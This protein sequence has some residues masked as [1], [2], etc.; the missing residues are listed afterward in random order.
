MGVLL[1]WMILLR[2]LRSFFKSERRIGRI[3]REFKLLNL[4]VH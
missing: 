1:R 2:T 3:G 4:Y